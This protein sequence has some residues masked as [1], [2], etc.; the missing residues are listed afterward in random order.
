MTTPESPSYD[1]LKRRLEAAESALT[2][3]REGRMDTVLGERE[4]LVVRLAEAEARQTHLKQVVLAIRK[5]NQL[6]VAENDPRRLIEQACVNLTETMGYHNA[7][8]A[9]LGGEA[10]PGLGLRTEGAVAA[11]AASGFDGGFESLR[12]R[13]ERGEFPEC[14]VQALANEDVFVVGDPAADCPDCPLSGHYGGRAGLV[15]RLAYDGVT[16]GILT[17]SVP[18][19]YAGD[20]EEQDLFN[21]VTGDLAFALHKISEARKLEESHRYLGLVIEGSGV[22]TWEWNVR[23]NETRFNKQWAAMLGYTIEELTPHDYTTWERLL[24]PEDLEQARRGLADCVAGITTNYKCE[25]R[26]KHKDGRWVWILDQGRIMTRDDMGKALFMFGT[27]TDI[28][29]IKQAEEALRESEQRLQAVF[30]AVDGVPIQGYDKDRRVIFWNPASERL[31]GYSHDEAT[32]R[33]L[34]ELIIPK[35]AREAVVEGIRRWHDQNIPIPAGE[36]EL[37]NKN[38]ERLQVYSNHIMII[39]HRGEKEMFCIDVDLTEIRRIERRMTFLAAVVENSND[40]VVVKDLDL[41]VIATNP[42]FAKLADHA[43]VDTMI[44]KTDAEIF[45]VTPDTE[46]IRSYMADERHA[47]TLSPGEY[48]LREESVVT[49]GG[50]VRTFLTKKYPIHDPSGSLIATGNI[51]TDITERKAAEEALR[52]SES[53][54]RR[55]LNALLDPEGDIG[56]L[57]LADVVDCDEVQS[58]MNDFHALTDIGVGILDLDGNILVG[59]GYQD[60]CMKFH[61]IHPEAE[62]LCR[63]SDTELTSGVK[64]GTFKIYKCKNNLWDMVTPIMVGGKHVGNLF[65]GQFFFEGEAP[66]IATFREQARRYGFDEAAYLKAYLAIPRWSR[67]TVDRVMTFYC[68]LIN[69]ISRLSYARIKLARTTGTL[70]ES[71]SR[72]RSIFENAP[73]GIAL[74]DLDYRLLA[75]NQAYAD[76]LG[77]DESEIKTLLLKDFTHPDDLEENLRLQSCL[78]RG[79]IDQYS[80]EKR[81]VRKNGDVR[82]GYLTACLIRDSNG[83]P[84]NFLGHVLDITDRKQ[85][86]KELIRQQRFLDLHNRISTVFLTTSG[87]EVFAGVLD[88]IL[89]LL[90]SRYGYFGYIDEAG[91]LVCPSMTRDV[92]NQYRVAEK[93]IVFPRSGW[94]GLWGRSLLEKRTLVAN[95][96]LRI[97]QGHMVLEN[98]LA[99]PIVHHDTLIGQFV[100]ANKSGGYNQEDRELLE[101]AA[102]H[103]APILFAIREE[104][105]QKVAHENLETQ[106][107]QAQ[108]MEAVGRLAG[109]VA[110]DFNNMLFIILGNVEMLSEDQSADG[111]FRK[112]LEAIRKAAEYSADLTRQLLAFARKQTVAPRVIDLN[113]TVEGML[114][115]LRRLIG[116]DIDMAWIP[117]GNVQPVKIDPGQIDQILANL[118]VNARDAIPGVGKVTIE[119]GNTAFDEAYC[120]NH[121]GFAPGEYVMLA[122]SDNGCGM[123]EETRANIF[124]PFFTTKDLGKGT[125][126]GLATVYGAVKQNNGFINVYSE[127]GQGTTFKI[128]LLRHKAKTA[129]VSEKGPDKP[130]K[131]GRETI[132]LVEDEPSVLK[133]TTMMLER[134]G[135]TVVGA[136]TPGEAIRL[137]AEHAGHIHLLMTDVVMPEMNGRDLAKN[138]LSLYPGLKCLFMSGYTANV[139]AHHGILDEAVDFIQKPFSKSDL[140]IKLRKVLERN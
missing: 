129:P 120:G 72:F 33:A 119:T 23:T 102:A 103:T 55:K 71:E 64:P 108:K 27:H 11:A 98:A 121:V 138:I 127:P 28:T 134:Q 99:G 68:N 70:R 78:G 113:N 21:E 106:L 26:M 2:A 105:R 67:E 65:L 47:Q 117:G 1:E 136:S 74:V 13:L 52:K 126:L 96:N 109:G 34:E 15:C 122:V 42:A 123:D 37:Q 50:E 81:F 85:A 4:T 83:D 62:K 76:L 22:G 12:E 5:V 39:N 111:P 79:E 38:G 3:I 110:H 88:V 57:P 66:D 18:A 130:S 51:S 32:G 45:G 93:S 30:S 75:S 77:R 84:L 19:A 104:A 43:T 124:E 7:W 40:I 58:L 20:A 25:F 92:W 24:H 101:A 8:I 82:W 6:I 125:G 10:A 48:I 69:V 35:E 91:D 56:T 94:G 49:F 115:M 16:W 73:I 140:A 31:Y 86:E 132:L 135:Y 80:L 46:P 133:M 87:D 17:A 29:Q 61:R 114:K 41:R 14:M 137:A 112:N 90:E 139:I 107:R 60:V 116:E 89:R 100:V 53:R 131:R 9:L 36:I 97:P 95:E 44:G 128:Y 63:V 118:C 54:V 59:T